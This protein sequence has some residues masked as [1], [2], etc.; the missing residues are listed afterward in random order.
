MSEIDESILDTSMTE[1]ERTQAEEEPLS[2]QSLGVKSWLQDT[3]ETLLLAV[4]LFLVINAISGRYQVQ[5]QSMEPSLHEGQYII[6]SKITYRL[7]P[8]E[9]GDVVVLQPPV[10]DTPYIKRIIGLPG[11]TVEIADGRVWINGVAINEPYISGPPL[12]HGVWEVTEGHYF[13]LGDNRNNSSDSHVWGLLS[14]DKLIGKAIFCYWP[15]EYWGP[16][17]HYTYPELQQ[18]N[19]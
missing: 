17:P 6:A 10:G 13:V 7:H 1:E 2:S 4:I 3:L 19:P 12:Y 9:R 16:M 15:P 11:D 18:A 8:P 5:G 14:K